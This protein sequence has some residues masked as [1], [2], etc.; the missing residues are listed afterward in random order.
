M[1][2]SR[3]LQRPADKADIVG[4]AAAASGLADDDGQM[5]CV[6]VPGEDGVHNLSDHDEGRIACVVVHIF[7]PHVHCLAVVV[8]KHLDFVSRSLER[9]LQKL[10]VDGRHLGA[11]DGMGFAHLFGKG[12]LFNGCR[13]DGPLRLLLL[14]H[15]D[16]G[17]QG[18]HADA[19]RAQV[20]D[21]VNLQRRVYLIGTGQDICHF[22]R[23]HGVQ[24][25][26]EGVELD[27]VQILGCLYIVCRRVQP[28]VVHP[29][30]HDI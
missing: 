18:A 1:G 5:V 9:R 25:A 30:V 13:A 17:Q 8:G 22:V 15:P 21:L 12:Y 27:E 26:A 20:V 4:R 28:G 29:L 7:Q 19:R 14:A 16:G 3:L 10:E 24:T 6:V 23:C 2:V 11:E